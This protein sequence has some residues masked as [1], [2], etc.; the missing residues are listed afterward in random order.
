MENIA[1]SKRDTF[2]KK[3]FKKII[4]KYQVGLSIEDDIQLSPFFFHEKGEYT[5]VEP[6]RSYFA[7]LYYDRQFNNRR[8]NH[9]RIWEEINLSKEVNS[10]L[11][12]DLFVD[13]YK[14]QERESMFDGIFNA[15]SNPKAKTITKWRLGHLLRNIQLNKSSMIKLEELAAKA[16]DTGCNKALESQVTHEK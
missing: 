6:V 1:V 5:F 14:Y 8:I 10:E 12:I 15:Y 11:V 2:R 16:L 13:K 4:N 9:H 3:Y 7:F